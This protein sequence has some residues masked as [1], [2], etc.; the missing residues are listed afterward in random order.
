MN[1]NCIFFIQL[2][3]TAYRS[4]KMIKLQKYK[5]PK[6]TAIKCYTIKYDQENHTLEFVIDYPSLNVENSKK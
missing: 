5:D 2:K 1:L 4:M 6:I 3:K